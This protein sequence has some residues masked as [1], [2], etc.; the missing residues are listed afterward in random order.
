VNATIALAD[1]PQLDLSLQR[2]ECINCGAHTMAYVG[3]ATIGG[4]C[5]VCGSYEL[6]T[7]MLQAA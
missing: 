3:V 4:N 2:C 6:R 7:V 5:A 1:P